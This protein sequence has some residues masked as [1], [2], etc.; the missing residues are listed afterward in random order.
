MMR[1]MGR[2]VSGE[3][4]AVGSTSVFSHSQ[5][6]L[7]PKMEADSVVA[8]QLSSRIGFLGVLAA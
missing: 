2:G 1:L 8:E 7:I 6:F 4:I 5:N 3:G